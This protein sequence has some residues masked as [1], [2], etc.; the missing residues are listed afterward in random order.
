MIIRLR[1]RDGLERITVSFFC[2]KAAAWL[3]EQQPGVDSPWQAAAGPCGCSHRQSVSDEEQ[4]HPRCKLTAHNIPS[5]LQWPGSSQ[6]DCVGAVL[7]CGH[8]LC[9]A[10][11]LPYLAFAL[12]IDDK[13][14]V[15]DLKAAIQQQ[16]GV[17]LEQQRLSKDASLL[18]AKNGS[19][20][21]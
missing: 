18:T 13:A 20:I 1:S 12:Q 8:L 14:S 6:I 9:P 5:F 4:L 3:T 21:R 2:K 17:P 19:D 11:Q 16:L 7:I 15:A 10:L